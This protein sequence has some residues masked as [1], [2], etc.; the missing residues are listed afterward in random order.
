MRHKLKALSEP[1]ENFSCSNLNQV[2][3]EQLSIFFFNVLKLF[4][5]SIVLFFYVLICKKSNLL[6]HEFC[7]RSLFLKRTFPRVWAQLQ[8]SWQNLVL[9]QSLSGVWSRCSGSGEVGSQSTS[10]CSYFLVT[11]STA[12]GTK[13]ERKTKFTLRLKIQITH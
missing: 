8:V 12:E 2:E 10:F 4:S 6:R 9:D 13:P 11:T 7:I 3:T 1:L 5:W